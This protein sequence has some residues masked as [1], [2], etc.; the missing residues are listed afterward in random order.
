MTSHQIQPVGNGNNHQLAQRMRSRSLWAQLWMVILQPGVFFRTLSPL[1]DTRQ[2]LWI[3]VLIL[4]VVGVSAVRY[5]EQTTSNN[6][7]SIAAIFNNAG[8]L[9]GVD[10]GL[11][12]GGDF[13]APIPDAGP[14]LPVGGG[15][16]GSSSGVSSTWTTA[17]VAASG[18]IL[19]WFIVTVLLSEVSLFNGRSPRMGQNFQIAIWSSVPIGLMAALQLVYYAAGGTAGQV[20]LS[21]LLTDWSGYADL[22]GFLKSLI[23]SLATRMTLFWIWSL[24]LI[25]IGARHVLLGKWWASLL[26]V[27]AWSV[28]IIVLPVLSGDIE[29]PQPVESF[30]D[31]LQQGN[32]GFDGGGP[33]VPSVSNPFERG[34]EATPEVT[35]SAEST[36]ELTPEAT[37]S[38]EG[39]PEVTPEATPEA[40]VES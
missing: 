25:Y 5:K 19:G 11:G 38:A 33:D 7:G 2:W 35:L 3:G 16:A 22:S 31:L 13:S 32:T 21:G 30:A 23:L 37:F 4:A 27:I 20:G 40:T 10:L 15:S 1:A 9:P 24:V 12:N 6:A 28:L 14:G 36:P 29:A 34:V 39:T 8:N 26:V 17:L 18:I